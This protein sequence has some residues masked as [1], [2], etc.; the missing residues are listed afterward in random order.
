MSNRR[1]RLVLRGGVAPGLNYNFPAIGL[2]LTLA[3]LGFAAT[4][5][6]TYLFRGVLTATGTGTQQTLIHVDSGATSNRYMFI[7]AAGGTQVQIFRTTG[8]AGAS[9]NGGAI[10]AATEFRAG[11]SVDGLGGA[12]LSVNGAASVSVS[13]GPTSG[14]TTLRIGQS[15][16]AANPMAGSI[17]RVRLFPATVMN[18][19]TLRAAV[20]AL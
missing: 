5:A 10:A 3:D 4:G 18:D 19:A 11:M 8:G 16:A 7:N 6:G 1:A 12:I 14:L 15:V 9:A 20:L 17:I 2:T 13:A